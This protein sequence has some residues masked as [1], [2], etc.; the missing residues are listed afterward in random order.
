[1]KSNIVFPFVFVA[2]TIFIIASFST[3]FT[4]WKAG[5]KVKISQESLAKLHQ[6]NKKLKEELQ[7]TKNPLFIEKTAREKLNMSKPEEEIVVIPQ[8]LIAVQKFA[9]AIDIPNWKKWINLFF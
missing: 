8:E 7:V 9:P 5:D 4:L 3:I 1:M 2:I 6:E